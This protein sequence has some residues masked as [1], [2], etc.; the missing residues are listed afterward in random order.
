M[1]PAKAPAWYLDELA[2][3]WQQHCEELRRRDNA[4]TRARYARHA[5]AR[6]R[7]ARRYQARLAA[8]AR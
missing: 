8:Q 2:T 5:K 3:K 1:T 6:A 7:S 4:R